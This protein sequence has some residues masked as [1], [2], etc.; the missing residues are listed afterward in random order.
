[1]TREPHPPQRESGLTKLL[2]I[3]LLLVAVA[4]VYS[5]LQQR[6]QSQQHVAASYEPRPI[7]QRPDDKLGADEQATI[8]V[9]SRFSRSVVHVTSLATRR[10]RMT[11]DVTEIPQGVGSGFVWDQDGHIVT[12]FHV[13]QEGDRASVTLNDGTTYPAQIIGVAPDKDLAVLKIDAP[14]QKLLPL[15]VGQSANLRVGQKVL[16]IGNPF[17]LDQTLTTGVISGLGREIKSV[18][19]RP[20]SDVIQTDASI[21]PGNSGGPLLDSSGRLIGINTAIYSPSGS[22]AGIGFA[23]PV[24]TIN[25]IVPELLAHGKI[26]RPG[27]GINIFGDAL[28]AQLHIDGVPI[29]S[30]QPGGAADQAGIAGAHS[31]GGGT[32]LGDVIVGID[33]SEIHHANDLYK[34]LDA[35][36]VGDTV[37]VTVENE[38][39][40]RT[41]KVTLQAIP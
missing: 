34:V 40:R 3:L 32:V 21:N 36:K 2:A 38:G 28:A 11:L 6:R 29:M 39:R 30:V 27:L 7:A 18:S 22:S 5:V 13:V 4:L 1:M 26:T 41:V 10:D 31:V 20:I 35:H 23:V 17:G 8:D 16:A 25:S 33:Q 9:F 14:P 37:D 24:D 15:P 12:N 19:G